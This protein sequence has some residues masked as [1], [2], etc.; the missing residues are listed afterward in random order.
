MSK[1]LEDMTL[2]E[3][4]ELF[5]IV[6]APH[7]P[8][9][10]IWAKEEIQYLSR[11]LAVYEPIITHIGSTA[12]PDIQAKPIIDLL[13]EV[14]PEIEWQDIKA[15]MERWGYICMSQSASRVSFNKGYTLSGYAEKVFHIHYHRLGDC[16][17]IIFRDFLISHPDYAKAYENLKKSLLPIFINDRDGYTN[18]KSQFVQMILRLSKGE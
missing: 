9:W 7:N 3:L 11:I 2:E 10:S 8:L 18:A 13:V 16:D 1:R 12:I 15:I 6:L 4:W 17:E 14:S 5:P